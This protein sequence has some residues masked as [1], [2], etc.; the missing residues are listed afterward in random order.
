MP[1]LD[2]DSVV[3]RT[4]SLQGQPFES[5]VCPDQCLGRIGDAINSSEF[6][7]RSPIANR[8][9]RAAL[10]MV[11]ES[12]HKAEFS[13]E[14]GP[15]KGFTGKMIRG[16]LQESLNL[17]CIQGMDLLL[18]NA[19]QYQCSLGSPTDVYRDKIFR[20]AWS[21]G[22]MADFIGRVAAAWRPSDVIVNCCTKGSDSEVH[23][24]LRLLVETALRRALPQIS[25]MRRMHPASW[26][27]KDNIAKEWR[28]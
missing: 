13:G 19:I 1:D 23:E 20:A 27:D 11:L 18:I 15:A 24:P 21:D 7:V 5:R 2:F 12:P 26:R 10:L 9:D 17:E 28:Y 4:I 14:P 3:G 25:P 6:P 8:S 16:H 22:G